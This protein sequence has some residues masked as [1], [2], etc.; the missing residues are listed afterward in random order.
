M[1]SGLL[2]K[3]ILALS[4]GANVALGAVLVLRSGGAETAAEPSP[5]DSVPCLLATLGLDAGQQAT[6]DRIR[7]EFET[8]H[9]ARKAAARTARE[10]LFAAIERMG[11]DRGEVDAL[12]A[13]VGEAQFAMRRDLVDQLVDIVGVLR[14]EQRTRFLQGLR[15]RF[16]EGPHHGP[17][18]GEEAC[19]T[20][21]PGASGGATP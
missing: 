13:K 18:G 12:L 2:W 14:P 21:S 8:G 6:V 15:P 4:L 11:T 5:P 17:H 10:D 20:P 9:E 3:A 7:A 19:G 1:K 16:V